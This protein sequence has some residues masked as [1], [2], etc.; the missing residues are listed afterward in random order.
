MFRVQL[1]LLPKA[2]AERHPAQGGYC[3]THLRNLICSVWLYMCVGGLDEDGEWN[4][5]P[6]TA[7]VVHSTV[8]QWTPGFL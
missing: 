6:W 1:D 5:I 4:T 3:W 8:Q 7:G 2:L